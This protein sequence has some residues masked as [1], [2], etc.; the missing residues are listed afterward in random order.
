MDFA[1]LLAKVVQLVF[2]YVVY[3]YC[4]PAIDFVIERLK[5]IRAKRR[6]VQ[7]QAGYVLLVCVI[8]CFA[9]RC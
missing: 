5:R 4:K 1:W 9:T 8:L 7:Y 6:R 3:C 2:L